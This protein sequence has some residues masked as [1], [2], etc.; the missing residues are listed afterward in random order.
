[1]KYFMHQKM[2]GRIDDWS[3]NILEVKSVLCKTDD[4]IS[5]QIGMMVRL[6]SHDYKQS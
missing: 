6:S 4:S 3:V 5:Y 1:M 2:Q